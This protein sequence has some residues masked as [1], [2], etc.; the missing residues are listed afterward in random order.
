MGVQASSVVSLAEESS[1][2]GASVSKKDMPELQDCAPQR[3]GL[4]HL[5][6]QETQAETGLMMALQGQVDREQVFL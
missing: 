4:R 6:G 3:C 5:H 2:E 1:N